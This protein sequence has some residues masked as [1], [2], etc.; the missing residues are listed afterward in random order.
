MNADFPDDERV[1][2][3]AAALCDLDFFPDAW[4]LTEERQRQGARRAAMDLLV[5]GDP[6]AGLQVLDPAGVL[7]VD[8]ELSQGDLDS[9]EPE[10]RSVCRCR[11][12]RSLRGLIK[13][14][15]RD[16]RARCVGA[17]S[18]PFERTSA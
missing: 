6:W 15:A 14:G 10:Q 8:T 1:E 7:D 18:H 9:G 16:R 3:V 13:R 4:E 12:A 11:P 5:A 2:L 17:L